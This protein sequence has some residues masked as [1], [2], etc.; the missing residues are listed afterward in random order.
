[1]RPEQILEEADRCV[2]C[3]YCLPG[4]PTYGLARDEGES[5]RGRI[6]LIQGLLT[7]RVDSPR[8]HTHLDHCLACLACETA[9]PTGVQYGRLITMVRALQHNK[10]S[11]FRRILKRTGL[12]L[13]SRLP[14]SPTA[15]A[16]ARLYQKIGLRWVVLRIGGTGI[17]RLDGLLPPLE[18]P[19]PW[20]KFYPA[21]GSLSEKRGR[22]G[23][24]TGCI[25]RITDQ[26]ALEAAIRVLNRLGVEVAIPGGQGCCGAM[27]LHGGATE[28]AGRLAQQNRRAF[29]GQE[30]DA[31]VS[32]ASGCAAHLANYGEDG[33]KLAA[34]IMD[35]SH[36][37]Q[38]LR[39]PEELTIQPLKGRVALHTPCSLKNMPGDTD[40]PGQ[41][42]RRIPGIDLAPLAENGHC[43][44]AAGS[45]LLTQPVIANALREEKLNAL[46]KTEPEILV[47]SNTGCAL[48][49]AAGIRQA[50]LSIEV[51]HPVELLARQMSL[52]SNPVTVGGG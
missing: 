51:L 12:R 7:G 35:I 32:V 3:G 26:P 19:V 48:H 49:L 43:C 24:F 30:L 40:V 37:L 2:K 11:L 38:G 16:M 41:L 1:M 27:H 9:C 50:D 17:R 5:P 21:A 47:T 29:A 36:Y 20:S 45:Y 33:E 13:L 44:G 31:I 52:K 18:R 10:S 39:W 28:Q 8:L 34:P 46:H 15:V 6:A 22:V 42:L 14:Y 25:G 23:L 4:C